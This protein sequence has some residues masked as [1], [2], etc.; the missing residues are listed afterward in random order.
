M[1]LNLL[2]RCYRPEEADPADTPTPAPPPRRLP[3]MA[4][5]AAP[6][7][8]LVLPTRTA[9]QSEGGILHTRSVSQSEGG[10]LPIR[11]LSQ[12]EGGILPARSLSQSEGGILHT[13][14]VSQSDGGAALCQYGGQ[15]A[16]HQQLVHGRKS[17]PDEK[18]VGEDIILL[19]VG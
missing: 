14:S 4:G 8:C 13:R 15:Q 6:S 2:C 18:E 16:G 5:W 3:Y 11:S 1:A 17:S 9:G 10:I 7:H 12:S 19:I